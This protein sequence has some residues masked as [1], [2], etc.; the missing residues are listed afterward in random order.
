MRGD[1][2]RVQLHMH[3]H[4]NMCSSS[5]QVTLLV[6]GHQKTLQEL[7]VDN[8]TEFDLWISSC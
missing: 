1:A 3:M 6:V 7:S 5:L 2:I 8:C 4:V